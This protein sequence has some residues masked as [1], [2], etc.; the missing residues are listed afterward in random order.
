MDAATCSS[1]SAKVRSAGTGL[2]S[3]LSSGKSSAMAISL[4]PISF[5]CDTTACDA[6]G[7][8]FGVS[9]FTLATNKETQP[10]AMTISRPEIAF[11]IFSLR[12]PTL[13]YSARHRTTG[14]P[15]ISGC[16][17][18]ATLERASPSI[19]RHGWRRG[20]ILLTNVLNV[21]HFVRGGMV[22]LE[23]IDWSVTL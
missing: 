18:A 6:L 9:L 21:T 17:D 20:F 5:H 7:A 16:S 10:A 8:A 22:K 12:T 2:K 14:S 11:F 13:I 4:R 19:T 15:W 1:C 23:A 3:Y